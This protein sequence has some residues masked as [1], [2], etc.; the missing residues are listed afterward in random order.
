M[1]GKKKIFISCSRNDK[2]WLDRIRTFLVPLESKCDIEVWDDG[3]IETGKNWQQEIK[4]A[5]D[6]SRVALLLISA[7]FIASKFI[8]E[9]ELP[10]LLKKAS[11]EKGV[12][13]F[14]LHLSPS[15]FELI[16]SLTQFQS[17][18][19]PDEDLQLLKKNQRDSR[20]LKKMVEKIKSCLEEQIQQ[21]GTK[22]PGPSIP[23]PGEPEKIIKVKL[24]ENLSHQRVLIF[25]IDGT[26]LNR[27]EFLSDKGKER[28]L[29][30]FEF[31]NNKDFHIVFI[32]GNDFNVQKR[33]VLK[34][35]IDRNLAPSITCFSDGG[36]RL[37]EYDGRSNYIEKEQYSN[38]NEIK[39]KQV[40]FIEGEFNAVFEQFIGEE[41]HQELNEPDTWEINRVLNP[42]G[43][44]NYLDLIVHPLNYTFYERHFDKLRSMIDDIIS[45]EDIKSRYEIMLKYYINN[46][47]VLRLIGPYA[48][49]DAEIVRV[50]LNGIFTHWND[51]KEVARPEIERRGEDF[52]SQI[53]IKPF[54][55]DNLR[56]EFL[57]IIRGRLNAPIEGKNFSIHL[58]GK[59]T[60]DIQ[61]KGVDKRKA[62]IRLIT[63]DRKFDPQK[64]IYFGDEF[65]PYGNDYVVAVMKDHLRPARIIHVGNKGDTPDLIA[66]QKCFFVDGNGPAGTLNYLEFLKCELSE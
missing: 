45:E 55:R 25:D 2:K 53:A 50:R 3:K 5:I 7:D 39:E 43:K 56:K 6:S 33:R 48:D 47:L 59:T 61:L 15:N 66:N 20:L 18:N 46:A 37:F 22:P 28:F 14:P 32:T 35:I 31:F 60:I 16:E 30:L 51:F 52:C 17:I 27:G 38:Q 11:D 36:S 23:P 34:P 57:E 58:G 4:K 19:P 54:K 10:A 65:D 41:K 13:I 9:N 49:K 24:P 63:G 12:C 21:P 26:V 1:P 42:N 62:I 40:E 29:E 44:I 8:R 64:M